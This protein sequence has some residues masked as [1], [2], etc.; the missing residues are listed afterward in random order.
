MHEARDSN[1]LA[2]R[3]RWLHIAKDSSP[4]NAGNTDRYR[5]SRRWEK[6]SRRTETLEIKMGDK[7]TH[8]NISIMEQSN[9]L[10]HVDDNLRGSMS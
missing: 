5:Q 8:K 7:I 4:Q 6:Y 9:F 2:R 3:G 10:R 1:L